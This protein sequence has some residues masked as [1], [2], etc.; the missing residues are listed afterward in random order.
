MFQ[1]RILKIGVRLVLLSVMVFTLSFA[2]TAQ[3]EVPPINILINDSPWLAGFEALVDMYVAETGN[4]VNLDVTPFPG[5]LQKSVNAVQ[6]E[7]SPYDI[8]NLNEQWYSQFY[9]G[10]LVTPITEIDPEFELDPNIIEYGY[11]TRWD[12][13]VAYSTADGDIYG[14]PINGNIQIFYYRKDLL[15]AAGLEVPQTWDEVAEV[16]AAIQEANPGVNGFSIRSRPSN[17]EFMAYL[18]SFGASVIELDDATGQWVVGLAKPEAVDALEMWINLGKTYGPANVA[19]LGQAENLALMASGRLAMVHMVSAA[20]P[21]FQNEEQSVVVDQVGAAVVPG[22]PAGRATISGIWVMGIPTNID[23][24]RQQAALT[25]LKWALEK[26]NQIAY[27]RAGGIPVRQDVYAELAEDPELGWWMG[28]VAES[29]PYI[30][31]QP[32]IPEVPQLTEIIDR[33]TV[34]ALLGEATPEEAMSAAAA[35]VYN[36]LNNAGYNVQPIE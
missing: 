14:L 28:A 9:N 26:D 6:G 24:A 3:D 16:A 32:R 21:N 35:E 13:E 19:D 25:F 2:V 17:W 7:T 11:S 22:G 23:D 27:A 33:W 30:V 31:G 8:I 1:S 12:P 15:E 5:M 20:A 10:A 18:E 29:T 36:V 4:Q 34:Q